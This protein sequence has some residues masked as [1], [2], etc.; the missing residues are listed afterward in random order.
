MLVIPAWGEGG[1]EGMGVGAH[2]R[3]DF[4]HRER[5]RR[6]EVVVEPDHRQA[7]LILGDVDVEV[8][9]LARS[10]H[11]I[12]LA[13][14]AGTIDHQDLV[15]EVGRVGNAVRVRRA[16]QRGSAGRLQR[17][18]QVIG[19]VAA[20]G[21]SLEHQP[22]LLLDEATSGNG[23]VNAVDLGSEAGVGQ[24]GDHRAAGQGSVGD[25]HLGQELGGGGMLAGKGDR[26]AVG[27]LISRLGLAHERET[28]TWAAEFCPPMIATI[29]VMPSL[30]KDWVQSLPLPSM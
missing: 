3:I 26:R 27:Q 19:S 15:V 11:F 17:N 22:V 23:R 21:R 29:W 24:T 7:I 4:L 25:Q 18:R 6:V 1:D 14:R 5:G 2:R 8:S 28:S 20:Q 12:R 10:G 13:H 9:R 30:R 16:G